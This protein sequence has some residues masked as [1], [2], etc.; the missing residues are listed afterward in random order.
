METRIENKLYLRVT[1]DDI[2]RIIATVAESPMHYAELAK[3]INRSQSWTRAVIEGMIEG[4]RGHELANLRSYVRGSRTQLVPYVE[5][6]AANRQVDAVKKLEVKAPK[7]CRWCGLRGQLSGQ[8]E[9]RKRTVC[10]SCQVDHDLRQNNPDHTR[11]FKNDPRWMI[12]VGRDHLSRG[13][14]LIC[15]SS[16]AK[17][18]DGRYCDWRHDPVIL[19]D[20]EREA[21]FRHYGFDPADYDI[22]GNLVR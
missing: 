10:D 21:L 11:K 1:P 6:L 12:I 19:D 14:C 15:G 8:G 13:G 5:N 2:R 22:W 7:V 18:R 16:R 20:Q 3:R 17:E 9:G 4:G